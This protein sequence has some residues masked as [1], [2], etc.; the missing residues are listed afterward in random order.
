[1]TNSDKA[2]HPALAHMRITVMMTLLILAMSA[3]CA[4]TQDQLLVE[5]DKAK[6]SDEFDA[7]LSIEDEAERLRRLRGCL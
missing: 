6:P 5:E 1:M 4:S 2:E 7:I 3:P